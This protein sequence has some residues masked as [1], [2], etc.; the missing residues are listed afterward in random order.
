VRSRLRVT[1]L[2]LAATA[3][4]SHAAPTKL[5]SVA[6]ATTTT[7]VPQRDPRQR[8]ETTVTVLSDGFHGPQLCAG[9]I[10]TSLPPQCGGPPVAGLDWA[11]VPTKE[12]LHGTTWAS[13]R[14]VGTFDGVT[15]TLTEPPTV[16]GPVTAGPSPPPPIT[17]ACPAP[18]G[19]WRVVD[20]SKVSAAQWEATLQYINGLPDGAGIWVDQSINPAGPENDPTKQV[21]NVA[22]SGDL[23]GHER[24]IRARWGGPLCV[25]HHS[26]TSA[27]LQALQ[28]KLTIGL[29]E[30]EGNYYFGS[31]VDEMTGVLV[32][33]VLIAD[34]V[35]R[36][37]AEEHFGAG[38]V[39]LEGALKPVSPPS[40]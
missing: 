23:A 34:D 18:A 2:L 38:I 1:V 37:W 9:L 24:D 16:P 25:T 27:E 36:A 14:L 40:R 3:A 33:Q 7:S 4:C 15:F 35:A 31:A 6:P 11:A 32:A 17:S 30:A 5:A 10:E 26:R 20:P 22:F 8:Y 39:R 29:L 21:L 13:V 12:S 19:G 28:S